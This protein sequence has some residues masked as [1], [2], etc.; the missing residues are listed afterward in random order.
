MELDDT[1]L[2]DRL[3]SKG[4]TP[5]PA[6]MRTRSRFLT[7]RVLGGEVEIGLLVVG[8]F[9]AITSSYGLCSRIIGLSVAYGEIVLLF[10]GTSVESFEPPLGGSDDVTCSKE[11]ERTG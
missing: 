4:V 5:A 3:R 7:T 1:M 6:W 8:L 9:S 11:L 10:A 2:D